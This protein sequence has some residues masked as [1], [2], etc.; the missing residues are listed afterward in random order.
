MRED[1]I[2]LFERTKGWMARADGE[3]L[4]RYALKGKGPIVEVGTYAGKSTIWLGSAGEQLRR[5]V[6]TIDHHRGNPE[7]STDCYDGDL[8]RDGEYDSFPWLRKT[9]REAQLEHVVI[10]VV[11]PSLVV[12]AAWPARPG[13]GFCF[14]DGDHGWPVVDDMLAWG[15]HVRR[16]GFLAFHDSAIPTI[17]TAIAQAGDHGFEEVDRIVDITVLRRAH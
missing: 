13:L 7:M 4:E 11:A 14:I 5:H 8:W 1:R 17:A 12:A 16:G 2:A 9:L 3:A 10:P 15:P 6:W